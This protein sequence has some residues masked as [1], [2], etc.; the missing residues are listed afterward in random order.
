MPAIRS[1][2]GRTPDDD[3][4]NDKGKGSRKHPVDPGSILK[5]LVV[6]RKVTLILVKSVGSWLAGKVIFRA[7]PRS[8][9]Q[10][11]ST[12]VLCVVGLLF[13]A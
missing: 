3:N 6:N 7:M 12:C 5:R 10:M 2:K 1:P 9:L 11:P 8:M 4:D 13:F